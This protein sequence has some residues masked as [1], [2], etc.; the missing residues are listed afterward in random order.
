MLVASETVA[1]IP[2][3]ELEEDYYLALI[4]ESKLE[5]RRR[6]DT[7]IEICRPQELQFVNLPPPKNPIFTIFTRLFE[8]KICSFDFTSWKCRSP[9]HI[10]D[11]AWSEPSPSP[12]MVRHGGSMLNRKFKGHFLPFPSF[13]RLQKWSLDLEV[14]GTGNVQ[15]K[16]LK[17]VRIGTN[18]QWRLEQ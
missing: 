2:L 13:P 18:R 9:R 1:R 14:S 12:P 5:T 3:Q 8:G 6:L 16:A 7:G 17:I 15:R 11:D 10:G 4:K